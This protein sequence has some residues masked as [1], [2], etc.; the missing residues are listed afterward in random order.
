MKN[1][2]CSGYELLHFGCRC[3]DSNLKS[4]VEVIIDMAM[5]YAKQGRSDIFLRL[6]D[7]YEENKGGIAEQSLIDQIGKK[8]GKSGT[9]KERIST[10][11]Q[12]VADM[13][14]ERFAIIRENGV[15][16]FAAYNS[17]EDYKVL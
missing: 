17:D 9:F 16:V 6:V 2:I 13:N 3:G 1:C 5:K 11:L 10:F 7:V 4:K 8:L 15:V 14:Y 12:N